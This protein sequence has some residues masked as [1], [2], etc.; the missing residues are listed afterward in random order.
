MTLVL[1]FGTFD[2]LH[3]GHK[4]Y[5]E[6]A[7]SYG[8]KLV[9]VI[10]LDKTVFQVKG[11]LPRNNQ[12]QRKRQVEAL[13]I[14]DRVVLGHSGDKHRIIEEI[15]PDVI[16]LGYDQKT[17]T[18]NLLDDLTKRNMH[19]KIVRMHAFHPDKYKSSLMQ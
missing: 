19:V 2:I 17:F 6:E 9:V 8:D 12:D 3:E 5:L 1:T 18:E 10:A 11:K 4:H 13:N 16:A 15:N 14:A 7:L